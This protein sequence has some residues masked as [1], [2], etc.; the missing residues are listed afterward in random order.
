MSSLFSGFPRPAL[1]EAPVS[2]FG[3]LNFFALTGLAYALL[4]KR[5]LPRLEQ[6][7]VWF[8]LIWTALVLTGHLAG[9]FGQLANPAVYF[10]VSLAALALIAEG[11]FRLAPPLAGPKPFLLASDNKALFQDFADPKLNRFLFAFLLAVLAIAL[12]CNFLIALH[13]YPTNADSVS[14]RLPRAFW[15][16]SE[17]GLLH[18]FEAIDKR[19]TFYP[20]NGMLLYLPLVVY[21]MPGTFHNL[22]TLFAWMALVLLVYRF[23]RTLGATRFIAL[24]ATCLLALTPDILIQSTATNDEILAATVLAMGVYFLWRWLQSGQQ[25]YILFSALAAGLSIGA[26]LHIVFYLPVIALAALMGLRRIQKTPSQARALARSIG[27]PVAVTCLAAGAVLI[28]PFLVYNSIS[29]GQ[30]YFAGDF[31]DEFF[32]TRWDIRVGLQNLL[33][34]TTQ[35]L[36]A[37]VLDLY[38]HPNDLMREAAHNAVNGF[39]RALYDP[40]IVKDPSFYHLHYR[41][42]GL[43]HLVSPYYLEYSLWAGFIYLLWPI[44]WLIMKARKSIALRGWF[45]LLA[46]SPLIWF[47]T[48]CFSTLYME[49]T[50]TYLAYYLI[51]AGPMLVFA[52][53]KIET[54]I[55]SKLRWSLVFFVLATHVIIDANLYAYNTF[56]NLRM[57][58][59]EK[60]LPV[61]WEQMEQP[62]I[63]E[64]GRA[65]KIRLVYTRWGLSYFGFMHHNPRAHYYGPHEPVK[66][67]DDTLLIM[68]TLSGHMWGFIPLQIPNKPNPG[69]TY[70]GTMRGWGL[71][72]VFGMG[73]GLEKR[74]P[75]QSNFI[76]PHL[77]VY[78]VDGKS[79]IEITNTAFGYNPDDHLEFSYELQKQ[80]QIV[81]TRAWKKGLEFRYDTPD[82]PLTG[83][84]V[85]HIR[86]RRAGS[87]ESLTT[88]TLPVGSPAEWAPIRFDALR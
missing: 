35:L 20:L 31:A 43:T 59:T 86:I 60:R 10:P 88:A 69:A 52:L 73:N 15:Y 44:V 1:F 78:H 33:I 70:L 47:L 3:W 67:S 87:Q 42:N 18:P 8:V 7:L 79:W 48:W 22:P 85:L 4:R 12:L 37:P 5:A 74:W 39:F 57:L 13:V 54:P 19:T 63:D 2:L 16:A 76:V 36:F 45:L 68:P 40:L 75:M 58:V 29:S 38:G 64:I 32:N 66:A 71:E 17:G 51:V 49:G 26:K 14:Y 21:G 50:P 83:G 81:A 6:P 80:G 62:I 27:W 53:V 11:I 82:D 65:A 61:D 34:Y 23:A 77:T 55:W 25:Y 46:L 28:F 84:Y 41:F 56:R 24:L 9:A 30:F 72:A